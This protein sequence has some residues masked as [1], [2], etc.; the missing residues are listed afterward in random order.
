METVSSN[1]WGQGFSANLGAIGALAIDP[2]KLTGIVYMPEEG[3]FNIFR[4]CKDFNKFLGEHY[5]SYGDVECERK[6][7]SVETV[8][9]VMR[10]V[11]ESF[12]L[13]ER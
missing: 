1:S 7:I 8:R 5:S 4:N 2:Y 12:V 9:N 11:D 6:K 13:E 10:E 3:H